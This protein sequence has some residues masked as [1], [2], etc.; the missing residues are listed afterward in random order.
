MAGKVPQQV[1]LWILT[2]RGELLGKIAREFGGGGDSL[3]QLIGSDRSVEHLGGGVCPGN[4][5]LHIHR[6]EAD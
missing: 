5:P 4:Q 3:L 2:G 1:V 6:R